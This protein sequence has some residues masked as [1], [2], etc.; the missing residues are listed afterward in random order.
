M[1]S[2]LYG[3]VHPH[4]LGQI[5]NESGIAVRAGHHCCQPLMT[6]MG[7]HGTARASFYVYNTREEV[8][9]LVESM[10]TVDKVLGK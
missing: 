7:I 2:F 9:F 1:I 10:K 3:D 8:D 5:L 6:S 4:D